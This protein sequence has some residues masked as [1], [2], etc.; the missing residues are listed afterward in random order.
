MD[1]WIVSLL[2][3]VVFWVVCGILAYGLNFA[4]FQK[5]YPTIAAESYEADK[6]DSIIISFAGPIGLIVVFCFDCG[7]YG[8]K[9]K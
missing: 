8:F 3:I 9:W 5:H 2:C 4:Y 1:M 7:K 6:R